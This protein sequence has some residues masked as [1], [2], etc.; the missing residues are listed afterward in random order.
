VPATPID[1]TQYERAVGRLTEL[2]KLRHAIQEH[3]AALIHGTAGVGKTR[4]LLTFA[5]E[6]DTSIY[7]AE[8]EG[9]AQLLRGLAQ[10]LRARSMLSA[11]AWASFS[12]LTI[13]S[14]KGI[15]QSALASHRFTLILDELRGPS[16]ALCRLIKDLHYMG[17]TPIVISARSMHMEDIGTLF[18][19]AAQRAQQIHIADLKKDVALEFAW[20]LASQMDLTIAGTEDVLR[21]IVRWAHG[22][23]GAIATMIQ[24]A[25]LPRYRVA[26]VVKI[27]TLYVDFR[28]GSSQL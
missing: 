26:C 27:N 10:A 25:K 14:Q 5:A 15:I 19:I 8:T 3:K 9:S 13:S 6:C 11:R 16:T 24:M 7:T 28:M 4:L 21:K 17:R 23:P 12:S 18:P 1:A 22:N 20:R 2:E